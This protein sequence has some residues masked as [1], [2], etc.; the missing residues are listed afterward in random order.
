MR[1]ALLLPLLDDVML[2]GPCWLAVGLVVQRIIAQVI[3]ARCFP[4]GSASCFNNEEKDAGL[5]YKRCNPGMTG[6]GP[7]CWQD[8]P[9]GW[10]N[11]GAGCAKTSA[12]CG[13]T[14]F[15][16]VLAPLIVA[17]NV[18]TLGLA[19]P[20]TGAA[21][22]AAKETLVIGGKTVAGTSKVGQGFV[23]VIKL[24]QAVKPE[25]LAKGASVA[26]RIYAAK[27]GAYAA[28]NYSKVWAVGNNTRKVVMAVCDANKDYLTAF[29]DDFA[30]QTSPE[31]NNA[32]DDRFIPKTARFL[33]E[34]WGRQPLGEM[35]N[36]NGFVIAQD[37]LSAVSIVDITGVTGVVSAYTKPNCQTVIPFPC[38]EGTINCRN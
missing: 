19:S 13:M 32:I 36:A 17:A 2:F 5:C 21:G 38:V 34:T 31:I 15:D 22:T 16:Q 8:C 30:G 27:T 20:A 12:Q 29:A 26:T 33:K 37:V 1:R 9:S 10:A 25:G 28:K 24:L 6:V 4:V 7:V 35:A 11:C 14:V 18:A 23:K 3:G